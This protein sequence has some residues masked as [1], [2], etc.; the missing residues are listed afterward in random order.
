[1]SDLSTITKNQKEIYLDH[2]ATTYIEKSVLKKMQPYL[3]EFYGNPSSLYNL[4]RKTR[5][6]IENSRKKI[7]QILHTNSDSIIFTGGGTESDNLAIF[8][9][10]EAHKNKGKHIITSKIEHPAVLSACKKLEKKGFEVTYLPV[11]KFGFVKI[12]DVVN[13]I[14][15][16]TIL[17]SIMY[18]NNEIGT[19][20]PIADIGREILKWRKKNNTSYPY[21]H[22]DACQAAGV[23]DLDVEKLHVDLMTLNGSKI[24]GPKGV[25]ILYKRRGVEIEAMILG[26]HQE[27]GLR[28]GT[29][30]TA[31]IVGIADALHKVQKNKTEENE[32]LIKIRNKLWREI[33]DKIDKVKLNGPELSDKI[34]KRLPNNLNLS[35]LDV[36]GEALILYLDEYG[37]ICS[38]GS[39][40]SSGSLSPSHVLISCG[41]SQEQAHSSLRLTLGKKNSES[42]IKYIMK[43]LPP[44][45]EKLRQISPLNTKV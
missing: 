15:S 10:A 16:N 27:M 20:E 13:K 2:A 8:G 30:N 7:A 44:I 3:N 32:R 31:A 37:V 6:A 33:T 26:G 35:I 41:L 25:G 11:D 24:Y 29:E 5:S 28:A 18:A 45:V 40:C 39:A 34:G 23:L 4:G 19:I 17:I 38:T 42:D 14:K 21:F 22:S 43:I 1:M 9:I 36:E 12:E